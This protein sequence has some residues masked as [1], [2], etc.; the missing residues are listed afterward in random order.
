LP[1]HDVELLL[2]RHLRKTRTACPNHRT[3]RRPRRSADP[4][5][6]TATDSTTQGGAE[7]RGKNRGRN[8][9]VGRSIGLGCGLRGR[10]LLTIRLFGSEDFECLVRPWGDRDGWYRGRHDA[11]AE[12]DHHQQSASPSPINV[13]HPASYLGI[14]WLVELGWLTEPG[15]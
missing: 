14:A 1:V 13:L 9:F 4:S 2:Q 8:G 11:R 15:R 7:C 3:E 5:G 10:K 6:V 12:R